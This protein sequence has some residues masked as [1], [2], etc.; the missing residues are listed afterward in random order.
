MPSEDQ[1]RFSEIARRRVGTVLRGKYQLDAVIGVGGMAIVYKAT[2]RNRAEYAVKML[3][4]EHAMN[5]SIRR[6]FLREGYAANSVKHPGAVRVVDDDESE[7]GV[8]FLVLELLDGMACDRLANACAGRLPMAAVCAI[9]LQVLD[10]LDAA[11]TQGIVHRDIKPANLFAL[12]DGA[13]KVLDFGIARVRESMTSGV[14]TTSGAVLLGTPA[15]MAPEQALGVGAD[16]DGRADIWAVGA[17]L[18]TLAAGTTVHEGDSG[19]RLLVHLLTQ[20]ARSLAA[21]APDAPRDVVEVVDRALLFDRD[22]RWP[23]ARAMRAALADAS[24]RAFGEL[25]PRDGLASLVASAGS[26]V[27]FKAD[28]RVRPAGIAPTTPEPMPTGQ[29]GPTLPQ[30]A[31]KAAIETS[32][33]V[34]RERRASQSPRRAPPILWAT[35]IFVG[36]AVTTALVAIPG[37]KALPER[38]GAVGVLMPAQ[39]TGI[40]STAKVSGATG[41]SGAPRLPA[42]TPDGS[43][44]AG[45]G[46]DTRVSAEASALPFQPKVPEGQRAT[47]PPRAPPRAAGETGFAETLSSEDAATVPNCRP[48]FYYDAQWNRVFKKECLH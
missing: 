40:G 25:P 17:S 13:V 1:E 34:S 23:S 14:H 19:Q 16:V 37:K 46:V 10:V 6:R 38:G 42:T 33:P 21:V 2:H 32:R 26:A 39:A 12:R 9:G 27:V 29:E 43:G 31:G 44:E 20:S 15:F 28:V 47:T 35:A 7:D 3:L 8:A 36:L 45:A 41:A 5:D 48:P 18:F 11:H 4:P 22:R 30:A 24:V